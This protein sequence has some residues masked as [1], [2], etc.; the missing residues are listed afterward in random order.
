M[1]EDDLND[2]EIPD[3]ADDD[4]TAAIRKRNKELQSLRARL[5]EAEGKTAGLA[6]LA[7]KA[8]ELDE[9]KNAGK[10]A[11]ER[12]TAELATANDRATK[13]EAQAARLEVAL[14]KGLTSVQARRLVGTNAEELAA[15]AD[16]LLAS[17]K[18]ADGNGDEPAPAPSTGRPA[19][20]LKG[21]GDPTQEPAADIRKV[22]DSIPRG[23]GF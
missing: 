10:G 9:L 22:V 18:Q 23:S 2:L 15:D 7:A 6:E 13:A 4:T 1:P 16:D 3:N 19:P 14:D 21:G 20:D 12:L 17:F 8:K 11:E 5:R